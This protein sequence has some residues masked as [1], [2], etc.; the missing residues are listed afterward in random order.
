MSDA[1]FKD[2]LTALNL[3]VYCKVWFTQ[4]KF[5]A[6]FPLLRRVKQFT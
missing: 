6:K 4:Q 3:K 2:V 1:S 5:R